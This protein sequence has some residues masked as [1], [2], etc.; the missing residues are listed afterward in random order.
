MHPINA[1]NMEHTKQHMSNLMNTWLIPFSN[2][3]HTKHLNT[4]S[5]QNTDVFSVKVCLQTTYRY[6]YSPILNVIH[7]PEFAH[8]LFNYAFH[9]ADLAEQQLWHGVAHDETT[10]NV[11]EFFTGWRRGC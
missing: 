2:G 5:G 9:V 4:P 3:N 6:S 1:W 11:P 8:S 7:M 10:C